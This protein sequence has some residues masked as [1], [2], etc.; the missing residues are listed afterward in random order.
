ML[1]GLF[2]YKLMHA[3]P[4]Q[5]KRLIDIWQINSLI[6]ISRNPYET[7]VWL[8]RKTFCLEIICGHKP[9]I[10]IIFLFELS[11]DLI[12]IIYR[13]Y[14]NP[15]C[16]KYSYL[17]FDLTIVKCEALNDC[18]INKVLM[19]Q[20]IVALAKHSAWRLC[21]I[22]GKQKCELLENGSRPNIPLSRHKQHLSGVYRILYPSSLSIVHTLRMRASQANFRSFSAL[23]LQPRIPIIRIDTCSM[24]CLQ[25]SRQI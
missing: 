12:F 21:E 16:P 19:F 17:N 25:T 23:W 2:L 3:K 20:L 14:F 9:E 4:V 11:C 24:R 22:Q 6:I 15:Y 10:S 18:D 13:F 5:E 8:Q 7:E 1:L